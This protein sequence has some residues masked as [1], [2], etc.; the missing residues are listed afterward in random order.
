MVFWGSSGG[1]AANCEVVGYWPFGERLELEGVGPCARHLCIPA[2]QDTSQAT[3]L[4]SPVEVL[5]EIRNPQ[6]SGRT[7]DAAW[8][9]L[10]LARDPAGS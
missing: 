2:P 7:L 8:G 4:P 5:R 1:E 10:E 9:T 3:F 6:W